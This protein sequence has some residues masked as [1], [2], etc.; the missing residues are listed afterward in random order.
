MRRTSRLLRAGL[1][2]I[3]LFT[4]CR[5]EPPPPIIPAEGVV[6]FKGK[7]LNKVQ[8]RFIPQIDYGAEYIAVGVTDP[9]GR[10]KLMCNGEPGACAGKNLVLVAED[11]I[12]K[13]L[14]GEDAQI[15]LAEYFRK[16]GGRPIPVRYA[17]LVESPLTATVSQEQK[18]FVFNLEP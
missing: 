11:D 8:V 5:R 12:P 3:S 18:E 16:L 17:N 13:R 6:L 4:G 9:N 1:V 15:E 10:F 2:F 14:Q 7:P